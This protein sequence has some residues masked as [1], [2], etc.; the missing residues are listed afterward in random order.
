MV[1]WL[2]SI[3]FC[4]C[5]WYDGHLMW[6]WWP[7]VTSILFWDVNDP[8]S[9]LKSSAWRERADSRFAPSQWETPL[10]CNVGSHWLGASLESAL[11]G[12]LFMGCF[13]K[14]HP[15]NKNICGIIISWRK[16]VRIMSEFIIV[17]RHLQAQWWWKFESSIC[18]GLVYLE[19]GCLNL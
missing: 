2:L 9:R 6:P 8:L 15:P 4:C 14:C 1:G 17:L 10:L 18:T 3:I 12:Y 19:Y 5:V 13:A 16:V 11:R 7:Q